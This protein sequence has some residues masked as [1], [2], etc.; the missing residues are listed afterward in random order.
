VTQGA[1]LFADT[2]FWTALLN[3][4]DEHHARALR[5]K[6]FI[7][8]QRRAL[9]TTEA[10][11][12]ERLSSCSAPALC[13]QAISGYLRC[14]QKLAVEDPSPPED[15]AELAAWSGEIEADAAQIP[16]EEHDGFLAA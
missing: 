13:R 10:V 16:A 9:V 15:E 8:D 14:H 6:K 4:R 3:V 7:A 11:L 12:W 5:W 2:S 1:A